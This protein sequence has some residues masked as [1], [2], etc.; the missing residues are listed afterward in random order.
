[1]VR[2][3]IVDDEAGQRGILSKILSAEGYELFEAANVPEALHA[4]EANDPAVVLTDLKMPGRGGLELIEETFKRASPPETIVITAYG[5]VDTAVKAMRLGAYHYLTKPIERDELILVVQR[6]AEKW[7]LRMEG[8]RLKRELER[9]VSGGLIAQSPAMRHVLDIVKKVAASDATVMIRGESGTGKERIAQ[10]IHYQSPRG[11]RSMQ[12][13]NCA[14]FPETLLE[15]ELFGYEKGAFSGAQS[16]KVGIIEAA[17]G[18][19]LFLDEVA[20]MPL[21]TQ[22]KLLRVLQ[23]RE[24]RRLGS[25]RTI[26]VDVRVIAATNKNL[27]EEIGKKAFREDLYYRLNIIPILI[28]PLRERKEDIPVLVEHFVARS[29]R[30]KVVEREALEL[31]TRYDWPGNVREL[32][33]VMQRI[34]VLS[35]NDTITVDDLPAELRE[36]AKPAVERRGILPPEG[37]SF[38]EWERSVLAAALREANGVMAEAAK[39]LGMTYRTFQYRA[40]KFGLKGN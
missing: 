9:K 14:A 15:S 29:G 30:A 32:E 7:T 4:I 34:A 33:A 25:T 11:M 18:S 1:M 21:S 31:L 2:V 10:M 40:E 17:S 27:E 24:I 8:E 6:A 19:T 36:G 20:D 22:A 37:T 23:E 39:R 16:R 26:P 35:S 5:S 28:P 12:S 3:L 38:E 13:I